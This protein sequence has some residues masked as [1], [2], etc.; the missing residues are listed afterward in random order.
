MHIHGSIPN[1][2][3]ANY[4]GVSSGDNAIAA[5]RA[6]ET[7]KRLLKAGQSTG[8]ENSPEAAALVSQ[9]VDS[10]HSQVLS[11]DADRVAASGRDPELG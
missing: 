2:Q 10:R 5:K 1:I 4:Y 3:S 6:A 7:R 11:G 8:A 9:W